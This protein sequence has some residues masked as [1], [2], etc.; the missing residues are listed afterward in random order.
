VSET[1]TTITL[2]NASG[3][4]VTLVRSSDPDI[5]VREQFGTDDRPTVA[6]EIK[7]GTDESNAHNRAGEAEKSHRKAYGVGYR[8]HWTIITTEGMD[9]DTLKAESPTTHLWFDAPQ[10]LARSGPEWDEFRSRL[11]GAVGIPEPK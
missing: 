7:G 6:I 4:I 9:L 5:G 1:E 10:V 3:R 8:D 11:C 2:K